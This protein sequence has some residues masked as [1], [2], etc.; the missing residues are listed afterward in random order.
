MISPLPP[1]GHKIR[2]G[3]VMVLP[4]VPIAAAPPANL[5]PDPVGARPFRTNRNWPGDRDF[6]MRGYVHGIV[7]A[8]QGLVR[9]PPSTSTSGGAN[10][11]G[12]QRPKHNL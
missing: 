8:G 5:A 4:L 9:Q 12:A 10:T 1:G 6:A 7:C 2:C 11:R 3:R